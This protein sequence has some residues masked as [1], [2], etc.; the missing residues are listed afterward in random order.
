ML[1]RN[2]E[3]RRALAASA[4]LACAA[5]GVLF[6]AL[7]SALPDLG[8][9][10]L[11]RVRGI[12][13]GTVAV[14]SAALI[15]LFLIVTRMRYRKLAELSSRLD[16]TLS[17]DRTIE[18]RSMEEG[19]LAILACEL[20]KVVCRLNLTVDEL[21][22]E[23]R[24]LSDSLADISHQLKTPLTSIALSLELIR[25]RA[26]ETPET[27]DIAQRVRLVQNLQARLEDLVAALLKLARIDAGAIRLVHAPVDAAE[28]VRRAFEPLA[29]AYD[30]ADVAFEPH[31]QEG[32]GY[33]GDLA[34]S[35]EA[36]GNIL[37]NCMEHTP[38]GGSVRLSVTEDALACRI[39]VQD[40]GPGIDEADLPHIF[41]RF[42]RGAAEET[43][44]AQVNPAGVGIGLALARS[45]VTAQGGALT[46]ENAVDE[47]GS[48]TGAAFEMT[49]FKTVV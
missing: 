9:E 30:I 18:F 34:W 4:L 14:V 48:R 29:I 46:A 23:K 36:L 32:A 37:K 8:S 13:C 38:A 28:L 44:Q 47:K 10:N 19:E 39:R 6:L 26:G 24:A 49:F 43:Q 25:T 20:D 2:K 33:K 16:R 1:L 15:A 41:E 11:A 21:E 17:G 42:Y 22:R 45:L 12:A 40:S 5:V 35:V 7:P 31:V 3:V 27:A